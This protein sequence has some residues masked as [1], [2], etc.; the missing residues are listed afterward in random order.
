M[1]DSVFFKKNLTTKMSKAKNR[2]KKKCF[3]CFRHIW[4]FEKV[5]FLLVFQKETDG[6]KVDFIM[7]SQKKLPL[8]HQTSNE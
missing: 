3:E 1:Y 4:V 8:K 7:H 2:K 6:D 5:S